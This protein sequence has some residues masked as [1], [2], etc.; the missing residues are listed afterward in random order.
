MMK[1]SDDTLVREDTN[2]KKPKDVQQVGG[3]AL[4]LKDVCDILDQ[5][6]AIRLLVKL[7]K[8]VLPNIKSEIFLNLPKLGL[9]ET[10]TN[11][12]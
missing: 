10:K 1:P 7:A 6:K 12:R 4:V 11:L 2:T 5:A 3:A 9:L 8:F